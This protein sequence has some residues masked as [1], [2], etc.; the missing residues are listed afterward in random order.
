MTNPIPPSLNRK[1]EVTPEVHFKTTNQQTHDDKYPYQDLYNDPVGLRHNRPMANYRVNYISDVVERLNA[2][3]RRP[4]T[5]AYQKTEYKDEFLTDKA[6]PSYEFERTLHTGPR[7]YLLRD[8]VDL[9]PTRVII[10]YN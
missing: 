8:E 5:M 6:D 10:L 4:L 9:G 2:K 7:N 3:P 1:D